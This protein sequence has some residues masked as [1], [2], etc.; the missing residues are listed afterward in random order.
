MACRLIAQFIGSGGGSWWM[1]SEAE[2]LY[3]NSGQS[4]GLANALGKEIVKEP[5]C[6][7]VRPVLLPEVVCHKAND[8]IP[9]A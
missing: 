4:A 2:F 7:L 8:R 1:K 3:G 6:P 5:L 9:L